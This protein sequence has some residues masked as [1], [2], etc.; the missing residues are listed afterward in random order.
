MA[1]RGVVLSYSAC[2]AS[3]WLG[4]LF[5]SQH[6]W[7]VRSLGPLTAAYFCNQ[8]SIRT[9]KWFRLSFLRR[10]KCQCRSDCHRWAA[11]VLNAF[12][13]ATA[14][15]T[16]HHCLIC[17]TICDCVQSEVW[18]RFTDITVLLRFVIMVHTNVRELH[19]I[20]A[21]YIYR[22]PWHATLVLINWCHCSKWT[23][24]TT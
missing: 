13:T 16:F 21:A 20:H 22:N 24:G 6:H 4:S 14:A 12:I 2:K 15:H 19:S 5:A 9:S 3:I 8:L 10:L 17:L 23:F 1:G 7:E 11:L 18:G